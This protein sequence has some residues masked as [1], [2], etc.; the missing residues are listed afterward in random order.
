MRDERTE[1]LDQ[2]EDR[3]MID[4]RRKMRMEMLSG[5]AIT[6][7]FIAALHASPVLF[8]DLFDQERGA[9]GGTRFIDGTIP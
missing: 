4:A 5:F 8:A 1:R 7:I 3:R 2:S 9:A 6:A